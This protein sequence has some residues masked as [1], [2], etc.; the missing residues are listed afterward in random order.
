M[1]DFHVFNFSPKLTKELNSASTR[2]R[3]AP[4]DT[5]FEIHSYSHAL[6]LVTKGLFQVMG[7]NG[8]KELLLYYLREGDSCLVPLW[9]AMYGEPNVVK[10]KVEKEGELMFLPVRRAY[11][12]I[13]EYP[14]FLDY[15]LKHYHTCFKDLT[16]LVSDISSKRMDQRVW[17][18]LQKKK[19]YLGTRDLHITH[20][21]LARDLG[22]N[23]VVISRIL[24]HFEKEGRLKLMRKRILLM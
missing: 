10:L 20:K 12:F 6:P 21:E 19:N 24:K 2:K 13:K 7:S 4:G 8:D 22:T 5:V 3:F 11:E 18:L 23:R 9:G 15:I 14:Q 17:R 1:D 16:T